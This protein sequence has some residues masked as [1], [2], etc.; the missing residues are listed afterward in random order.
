MNGLIYGT[1]YGLGPPPQSVALDLSPMERDVD[2][3]HGPAAE[4]PG[5]FHR[6]VSLRH[7][8]FADISQL[9]AAFSSL[10]KRLTGTQDDPSH[11]DPIFFA[12]T[13]PNSGSLY[14]RTYI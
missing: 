1:T 13:Y 3:E 9:D 14:N 5:K 11:T 12:I 7:G 6:R 10:S 8:D 2:L 4:C